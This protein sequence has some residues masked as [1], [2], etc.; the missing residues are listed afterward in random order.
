MHMGYAPKH[1]DYALTS[2]T[3]RI[4]VSSGRRYV[5]AVIAFLALRVAWAESGNSGPE[6]AG[7]HQNGQS[8][9]NAEQPSEADPGKSP[10]PD[11]RARRLPTL[12][13]AACGL[14]LL[15]AA[16]ADLRS[17]E[18]SVAGRDPG[19]GVGEAGCRTERHLH[20]HS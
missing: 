7:T 19:P 12:Y 3:H 5:R 8:F 4:S 2:L 11:N 14:I 6:T 13:F 20:E 9:L 18:R 15:I 17:P 16:A 1:P 10:A